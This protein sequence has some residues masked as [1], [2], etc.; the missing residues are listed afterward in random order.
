VLYCVRV[1]EGV[2]KT[3]IR[4]DVM[5]RLIL[6]SDMGVWSKCDFLWHNA[7][8]PS[9]TWSYSVRGLESSFSG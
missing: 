7:R 3:T 1:G 9:L 5:Y 6:C 8:Y 2:C 4:C